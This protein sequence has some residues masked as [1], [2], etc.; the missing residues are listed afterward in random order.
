MSATNGVTPTFGSYAS[1]PQ[2][3]SEFFLAN[4][5]RHALSNR[6]PLF[7]DNSAVFYKQ[8]SLPTG[9]VGTVRNIGHKAKK[10]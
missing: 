5:G 2:N 6:K 4:L 1:T 10:T 7:S 8:H 3:S 9:G